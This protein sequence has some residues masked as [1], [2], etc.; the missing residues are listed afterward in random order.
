MKADR[1]ES[2]TLELVVQYKMK[3]NVYNFIENRTH[4][5]GHILETENTLAIL[6]VQ[7]V[8]FLFYFYGFD[9]ILTVF[10][11]NTFVYSW[12]V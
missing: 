1:R 7:C 6:C 8:Y 11:P 10:H 2:N 9:E 3:I 12:F 5:P 4:Q